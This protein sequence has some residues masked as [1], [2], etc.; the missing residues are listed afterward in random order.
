MIK[1]KYIIYPILFLLTL[2]FTACEDTLDVFP[3]DRLTPQ[4][5][6]RNAK[7]LKLYSNQFYSRIVPTADALYA[8]N[9]DAIIIST[10]KD[11]V[12]GQRI[13]PADGGGW[14]FDALRKINFLLENSHN[15]EDKKV[16][17]EYDALAR[18]FRAYFYFEKVKR[19][20]EVPW[21]DKVLGSTDPELYKPRDSRDFVMSK[22]LED[23]DYAIEYLPAKKD[24]YRASKW[25]ALALKSRIF[26]FEGT[27]RKYHG[28]AGYEAYL[29]LC[30]SASETFIDDS[31]YSIYA[32][33]DTPYQD[34]F[35]SL[36]AISSEVILA[37]DYDEGISLVHNLQNYL[38]SPSQG[39]PGLA[40]H[41]VNTYLNKSG[42]RFTDIAN[43]ST[44]QFIDECKNRDPRLAQSIR[45]PGY[46]RP[47]STVKVA[48][49]FGAT[50]TGYQLTKYSGDPIYDG[51]NKSVNDMPV[52]RTAEVLL[53]FAEAKAERGTLTQPDIN[54]S[55]NK[56]RDRVGMPN[57]IKDQANSNPDP[58]LSAKETGYPNVTGDNKG[59][60]LEI[61]RERVI[62]LIMEGFRYYDLMRWKEG[63]SME[64]EFKGMYFPALGA[65]D[66]D[67]DGKNDVCF[68]KGTKPSVSATIFLEVGKGVVFT[69]GEK[70]N[71]LVHSEFPR[72]WNSQRDYLYPIP[73]KDRMLTKGALTQNPGWND[74]LEY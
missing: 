16:R 37:R 13:I 45:T 69:E 10:L 47:G 22:I 1:K 44:M 30:I 20:G 74:G 11:E 19:F 39:K 36:D 48:P 14:N 49:D 23:I 2:A 63:D 9:A 62:E 65:Y 51:W 12:T 59:V 50:L 34:L 54:K 67:G 26:L 3:D 32:V 71:V 42:T 53:N 18:F 52:F 4:T 64:K 21:Y 8:E 29:D 24:L 70:G 68:Y 43:Y 57:L 73:T 33:G 55:I 6:F 17:V 27:Y 56:L 40:K 72:K 61:R 25:T 5:Y 31:G 58:Y 66:L 28:I 35:A 46:T 7:E 38:T 41:I 15:C 60:I